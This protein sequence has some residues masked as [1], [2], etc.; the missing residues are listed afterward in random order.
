MCANVTISLASDI[1]GDFPDFPA[2]GI[3]VGV[4]VEGGD[5]VARIVNVAC[6][7]RACSDRSSLTY[8]SVSMVGGS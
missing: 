3:E 1:I 8:S 7:L 5:R 6:R 2:L 4:E